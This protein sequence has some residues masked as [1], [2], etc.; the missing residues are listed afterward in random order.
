MQRKNNKIGVVSLHRYT[1]CGHQ[2]SLRG[3]QSSPGEACPLRYNNYAR[4]TP[5][6]GLDYSINS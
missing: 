4:Q 2:Y 3:V 1:K 6:F 5:A